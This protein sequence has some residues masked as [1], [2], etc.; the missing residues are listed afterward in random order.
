VKLPTLIALLISAL[1]PFTSIRADSPPKDRDFF[2]KSIRPVLAEH[3]YSCH[4]PEKQRGGL[5]VDSREALLKGGDKGPAIV[6]GNPTEGRLFKVVR[7][8]GTPNTPVKHQLPDNAISALKLWIETGALWLE[9]AKPRSSVAPSEH[10]AFQPIRSRVPSVAVSGNTPIDQ[11]IIDRL[12]EKKLTLSPQA[13]VRTLIRR[14]TFDLT[15]LPPT[16]EEVDAFVRDSAA[17]P[18]AAYEALVDRLLASPHYGEKWGRHWLDV[19]RYADTKGYVFFMD[20]NFPWAWTYRDYVIEALNAD[21]P[22][23]QFIREQLAA[24]LLP[25][26]ENKKPLRALGFLTL[27]GRFM[28]NQHDILDDRIDVVTRGLMGLTVTCARCHDHKFDPIPSKDYYSLYA[29]F[30]ACDEPE[31]PPLYETPPNTPE[32]E[33]FAKELAAREKKLADFLEAKKQALVKGAK[34][35]VGEYLLAAHQLRDKPRTDDFMLLTDGNDLNPKMIVRYQ[36]YLERKEKGHDP[37]WALWYALALLP[38]KDFAQR[39]R[40]VVAAFAKRD[41]VNP[42]VMDAFLWQTPATMA[43]VARRYGS[44]LVLVSRTSDP[45]DAANQIKNVFDAPGAPANVAPG[46]YNELELLPDR[47]AQGELQKFRKEIEQFRASGAGAP[48]RAHALVDLPV[49]PP[50]RVFL[51]GNPSN[52]GEPVERQF[53]GLLA[54]KDRKPFT[55]G[56]GRLELANAIVDP[57]NP[58]TARVLVN[59]VWQQYFGRGLVSTAGDFGTRSEPPTHPELLDYVAGTFIA[60]G[61]SL[62]KLHKRI[63]MSAVYQQASLD[64]PDCAKADSENV[65]LWKMPRRRLDFEQTR[66]A[67]LFA[68]G[69]LDRK[70]G[71]ASVQGFLNAN[72]MR[73]TMYA[74][75]DR[76]NVPGIYRT[77]DFPAPDACSPRRDLTTVPPQALFLMNH[78]FVMECAKNVLKRPEIAGENNAGKRVEQIYSILLGRQARAEEQALA[79]EFLGKGGDAVWVRYVHALMQ[80][81]EFVFLD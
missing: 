10:W 66:D 44:L 3:C 16:P 24:D 73:R 26:G 39:A 46:D 76:L 81:N 69:K 40:E 28:N 7:A 71:G 27:G 42:I 50:Q 9:S 57:K 55:N 35:R 2:E 72:A 36:A 54:G 49:R 12:A 67:L 32:H 58:L 17:K 23:D 41:D 47:P 37:V 51:R 78:P 68:S 4:G 6:P 63:L 62:K 70:I 60:D 18:R 75:L 8:E 20:S 80:T 77:F 15:G 11:F 56:S 21:L 29:V 59:R 34:E 53:P 64:R 1:T 14:V 45:I 43:D 33:K 48:P 19:A 38:E 31:V 30:N 74:H 61:W 13:D 25:L 5:R 65:L 52:L 79:T 22:Y